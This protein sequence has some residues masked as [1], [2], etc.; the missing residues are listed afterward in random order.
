MEC[1][2]TPWA[3]QDAAPPSHRLKTR[4]VSICGATESINLRHKGD[5]FMT[6]STIHNAAS[7]RDRRRLQA[8]RLRN[9]QVGVD[10]AS[11]PLNRD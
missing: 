6:P 5:A 2:F 10:S 11:S 9:L 7:S 3:G 8:L 1:S 4:F